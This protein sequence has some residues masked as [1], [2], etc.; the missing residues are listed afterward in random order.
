MDCKKKSDEQ[1]MFIFQNEKGSRKRK[2]F[3][4]LYLR[5]SQSLTEYFYYSL[6]YDNDKAQDFMHDLF[7]KII[8]NPLSFD[9]SRN[10]KTWILCAA[11]NMCKNEYRRIKKIDNSKTVLLNVTNNIDEFQFK[12]DNFEYALNKLNEDHKIIIIL[13]YK[14]NLLTTEI[15]HVLVCP[16]GTIRSR[17]FY[18]KKE[19]AKIL[20]SNYYER[21]RKLK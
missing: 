20:N 7:L 8:E 6:N 19:L 15:A 9:T 5:Y 14:F 1:L 2:A 17:L 18:A 12:E 13:R 4:C 11:S 21:S 16:E 10:F 3:D